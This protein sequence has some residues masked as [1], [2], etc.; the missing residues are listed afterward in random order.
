MATRRFGAAA[1]LALACAGGAEAQTSAAASSSSVEGL[2]VTAVRPQAQTLLDRKVYSVTTDLQAH[3]GTAAD[4][5]NKIPSVSVDAD[6]AVSLRGDGNV[7]I[8]VDGKPSAQF[9]GAAQALSLL[10]FPAADI[11]R[12]EVLTN[13]PAQY[14]AEGTGGVINIVTRK[15]RRAGLTGSARASLGDQR[16]YQAG[17]DLAYN[18]GPLKLSGGVSL[19]QDAKERL[20]TSDRTPSIPTPATGCGPGS[21]RTSGCA[22]RSR[23]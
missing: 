8:L 1:L 22:A 15:T 23:R 7:T 20:I 4:V 19:R 5:L 2:V 12:I 11:D 14:K 10:E 21:A 6:G 9:S 18:D 17:L 16:R 3:A 13:P